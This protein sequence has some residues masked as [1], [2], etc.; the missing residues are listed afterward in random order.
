[1]GVK[2]SG[3]I[4]LSILPRGRDGDLLAKPGPHRTKLRIEMDIRFVDVENG[5][6]RTRGM[7]E[8]AMN[9]GRT[10]GISPVA[11]V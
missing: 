11:D 3:E 10:H 8:G 5:G 6:V 2:G 1:M 9:G 7:C 4:T